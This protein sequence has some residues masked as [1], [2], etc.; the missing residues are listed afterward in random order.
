MT[1][2]DTPET[3]E[4]T[5]LELIGAIAAYVGARLLLVA[6]FA[7]VIFGVGALVHVTVPPIVAIAFALVIAFP[8]GMLLFKSLRLNVNAKIAAFDEARARRRADLQGRLRGPG[9]STD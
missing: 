7:A 5:L 8:L 9:G 3:S 1:E 4:P 2:S 6:F